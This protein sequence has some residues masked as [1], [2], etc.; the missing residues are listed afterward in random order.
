MSKEGFQKVANKED[1]REG[2]MLKVE[3]NGKQIVL[4]PL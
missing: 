1:L 2:G 3:I 4:S